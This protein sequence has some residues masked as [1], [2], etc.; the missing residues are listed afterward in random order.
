LISKEDLFPAFVNTIECLFCYNEW[1]NNG[2][3]WDLTT[4]DE[5]GPQQKACILAVQKALERIVTVV[6]RIK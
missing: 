1:L 3:Y 4:K 5:Y 2:P 6:P